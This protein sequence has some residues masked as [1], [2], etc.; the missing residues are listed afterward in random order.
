MVA[1]YL[2]ESAFP[3]AFPADSLEDLVAMWYEAVA[4]GDAGL[5]AFHTLVSGWNNPPDPG[6]CP[7]P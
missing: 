4:G 1:A 3:D 6:Y 2:N 7:L 5:D